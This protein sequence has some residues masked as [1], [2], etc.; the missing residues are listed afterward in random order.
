V[1]DLVRMSSEVTPAAGQTS[2]NGRTGMRLQRCEVLNWGTFHGRVWGLDL[3][4]D[5]ALL[6]PVLEKA[7][8]VFSKRRVFD[9]MG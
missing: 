3:N 5:N 4:C 6:I 2:S 8:S 9:S 1:N 7:D